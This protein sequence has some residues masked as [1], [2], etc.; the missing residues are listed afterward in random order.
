MAISYHETTAQQRKLGDIGRKMMDLAV[1]E[2]DDARSNRLS[3]VGNMLTEY[4]APF[5]SSKSD[6]SQE[7]L[8]LIQEVIKS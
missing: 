4:G 6:F 8:Q 3:I 7:D 2:K 5:G 1:T